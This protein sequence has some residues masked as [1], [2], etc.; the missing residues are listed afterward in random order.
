MVVIR[1]IDLGI[2]TIR[3]LDNAGTVV[4]TQLANVQPGENNIVIQNVA[5][6]PGGV[7]SPG[8]IGEHRSMKTELL[9]Q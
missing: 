7:Y 8:V 4:R 9:K 1:G 3:M 2:I 6:L 5:E